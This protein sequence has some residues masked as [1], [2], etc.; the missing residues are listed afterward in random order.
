[1]KSMVHIPI[2]G[3]FVDMQHS[4]SRKM[5][6]LNIL[7]ISIFDNYKMDWFNKKICN[8]SHNKFL[9]ILSKVGFKVRKKIIIR[10]KF[11]F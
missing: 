2:T 4:S 10:N 8:L 3:E 9:S 7:S 11:K 1:M 5:T 6:K